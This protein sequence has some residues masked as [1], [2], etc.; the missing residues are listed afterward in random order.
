VGVSF[1]A[2]DHKIQVLMTEDT[3]A[4]SEEPISVRNILSRHV[5]SVEPTSKSETLGHFNFI[6]HKRK[7]DLV[8]AY[9][10]TELPS[11]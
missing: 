3:H 9:L 11:M 2:L 6:M 10:Q 8:K 7:V 1:E 4:E 5:I